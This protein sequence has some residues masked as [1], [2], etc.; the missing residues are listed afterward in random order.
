MKP[1]GLYTLLKSTRATISVGL[2]SSSFSIPIVSLLEFL[3]DL[4][5]A[6]AIADVPVDNLIVPAEGVETLVPYP[7]ADLGGTANLLDWSDQLTLRK[8]LK[9]KLNVIADFGQW[10]FQLV[11]EVNHVIVAEEMK[12]P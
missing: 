11:V 4:K 9:D 10:G 1:P 8:I 3:V 5:L 6:A 7:I 2:D 12:R